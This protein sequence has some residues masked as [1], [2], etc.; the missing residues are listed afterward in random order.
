MPAACTPHAKHTWPPLP[1]GPNRSSNKSSN[2]HPHRHN[3]LDSATHEN[4]L[5]QYRN[6]YNTKTGRMRHSCA[7]SPARSNVT[8]APDQPSS[9]HSSYHT[10]A[11]WLRTHSK[12]S[13]TW[14]KKSS[15]SS[16][17]PPTTQSPTP[18]GNARHTGEGLKT[19]SWRTTQHGSE[20]CSTLLAYS[21]PPPDWPRTGDTT[22]TTHHTPPHNAHKLSGCSILFRAKDNDFWQFRRDY[23]WRNPL[24]LQQDCLN[25]C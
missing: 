15:V 13:T 22:T 8:C 14:R 1:S 23:R 19:S 2:N 16:K 21:N 12:W 3:W 6:A 18:G 7:S 20:P 17:Q 24:W 9:S 10:R 5:P 4:P 11:K 25:F